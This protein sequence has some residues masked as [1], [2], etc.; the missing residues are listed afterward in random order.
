MARTIDVPK[1]QKELTYR[2]TAHTRQGALVKGN[3][4]AVNEM[5]AERLLIRQGYIPEHLEIAPSMFS[6]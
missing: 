6:L 5:A 1:Q 3:I 2:Y 4:K